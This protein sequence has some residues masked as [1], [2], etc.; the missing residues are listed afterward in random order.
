MTFDSHSGFWKL[1]VFTSMS[2]AFR[3]GVRT[4]VCCDISTKGVIQLADT[5][6][7]RNA[8]GLTSIKHHALAAW[9]GCFVALMPSRVLF[10]LAEMFD[11]DRTPL[12]REFLDVL[13]D[14]ESSVPRLWWKWYRQWYWNKPPKKHSIEICEAES[15]DRVCNTRR[16]KMLLSCNYLSEK[17]F[18]NLF[19]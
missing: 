15:S 19:W 13:F 14:S 9:Y 7:E 10:R 11:P 8:D 17:R 16:F 18:L 12:F 3:P 5:F 2:S 1:R 4:N 6:F